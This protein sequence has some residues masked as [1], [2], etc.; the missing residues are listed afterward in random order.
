MTCPICGKGKLEYFARSG[1]MF[2]YQSNTYE[3]SSTI[4]LVECTYCHELIMTPD[5][6]EEVEGS[7]SDLL[8]EM[9]KAENEIETAIEAAYTLH[10]TARKRVK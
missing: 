10:R 1:R 3:I 5:E 6:I 7:I 4:K 8:L 9:V 2:E